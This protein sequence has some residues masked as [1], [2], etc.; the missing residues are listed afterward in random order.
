MTETPSFL[1]LLGAA[2]LGGLVLNGMPCVLPMLLNKVFS[3]MKQAGMEA[4]ERRRHGLAYASGTIVA[5]VIFAGIVAALR[6][7]GKQLGW[8][9]QFQNPLFVGA[10][11][12]VVFLFALN[13]LGLFEITFGMRRSGADGT[14]FGSFAN[15]L[16][17]AVM[18]TPCSA[19]FLGTAAAF[20]MG[21]D[22][23]AWKT[24]VLF[25]AIGLGLA[26]P[27]LALTFVPA[28]AGLMRR[29]R[30]GV[31]MEHLK[32]LMGLVLLGTCLWLFGTLLHQVGDDA[33][34]RFLWFLFLMT[35]IVWL[36][37]RLAG[38]EH[39]ALRRW[40]VRSGQLAL[41]VISARALVDL[42]PLPP[43]EACPAP[44]AASA[45]APV[46][47]GRIAWVSFSGARVKAEAEAGRTVFL[48][49]TADWCTSCQANDKAF[50][51]TDAV[52]GA[53]VRYGVLPMRADMTNEN[54]EASAV[55][56]SLKI[57]GIPAYILLLPS[58]ER[59][60]LPMVLTSPAPIIEAFAAAAQRFPPKP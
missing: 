28:L 38:L 31:W 35:L 60:V 52:R 22:V 29:I 34:T 56:E 55:L 2:V 23:P 7:S 30:P 42:K 47:D 46:K 50:I 27:F 14:L 41:L 5:F 21:M 15:G 8:G 48:D 26:L 54:P 6:A 17:A 1:G 19:P 25:A 12:A 49:F 33:G 57:S 18:A 36:G 13:A 44:S 39:S 16:L 51:E 53:L 45:F 40:S 43:P 3:A 11:I 10:M 58:G 32:Q 59:Q 20:A 24:V 37:A 4:A 9:M